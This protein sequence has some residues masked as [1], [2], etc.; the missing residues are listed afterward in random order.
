MFYQGQGQ[1]MGGGKGNIDHYVT[2]IRSS[3][4]IIEVAGHCEYIEVCI[5]NLLTYTN[6][7][8]IFKHKKVHLHI[9]LN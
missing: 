7:V 9:S 6:C 2:P 4:I 1:R 3:R 5:L 8:I